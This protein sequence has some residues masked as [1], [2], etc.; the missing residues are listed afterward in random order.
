MTVQIFLM[1]ANIVNYEKM[2]KII[3]KTPEALASAFAEHRVNISFGKEIIHVA[4]SGGST[5]KI[6]FKILAK[7]YKNHDWSR[8][9][10]YWG[11]E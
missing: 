6:L 4:L 3:F 7:T 1:T 5:P 9:H 2:K 10:F 11:D 8:V